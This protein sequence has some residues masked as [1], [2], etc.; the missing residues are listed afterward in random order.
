MVVYGPNGVGKS[1]I[2]DALEATITGRSTLFDKERI[3]VTWDAAVQHVKGG[4]ATVTIRGKL[5][6][7]PLHITLGEAPADDLEEWMAE[8]KTASFVLR[9]YML[10]RFIDARPKD[11]YDQIEPFLNLE[12]VTNFEAG[13]KELARS[14]EIRFVAVSGEAAAKAQVIRQTFGLN[15]E[16][17]LERSALITLLDDR[18]RSAGIPIGQ[19]D[20]SKLATTLR[21]ELGGE[22]SSQK[23]ASLGA[24]KH[25]AQ[26]LTSVSL[27]LPLYEQVVAAA[28]ELLRELGTSAQKVPV[29]LLVDALHHI[30]ATSGDL[31]PVCEQSVEHPT[32]MARLAERINEDHAVQTATNTL[33]TRLGELT[34]ASVTARQAYTNFVEG[35]DQ[36]GF[37]PLPPCYASAAAVFTRLEAVTVETAGENAEQIRASFPDAECDPLFR[38]A[39]I[40]EAIVAVGGG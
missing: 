6:G 5:K 16:N 28:D 7:K 15:R 39:Q 26:Q 37:G 2:I 32:L 19:T 10:L 25:R 4:P 9:R 29:K 18:L 34:K 12:D 21:D 20:L 38:I 31:C 11:R 30:T 40:D 27:L 35:W 8:A 33:E 14:L 23:L 24:A 17:K 1:S 13:I 22:A 3:G 36:L